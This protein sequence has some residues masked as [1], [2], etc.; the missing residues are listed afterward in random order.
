MLVGFIEEGRSLSF[1][2]EGVYYLDLVLLDLP[3][4]NITFPMRY[5]DLPLTVKSLQR[6]HL[7]YLE[8]KTS[9]CFHLSKIL[10]VSN[11]L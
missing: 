10:G 2:C 11:G 5:L 9:K 6:V 3:A 7:Q 1:Q 4:T 8:H